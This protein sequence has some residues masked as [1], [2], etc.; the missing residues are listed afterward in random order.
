MYDISELDMDLIRAMQ[1]FAEAKPAEETY[2]WG[3]A[4]CPCGQLAASLGRTSEWLQ[5]YAVATATA[6]TWRTLSGLA[7]G[8]N[9][10]FGSYAN[11]LRQ[12]FPL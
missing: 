12:R 8:S 7:A 5:R 2:N 9:P 1:A 6:I 11:K 10:N 3:A 4:R